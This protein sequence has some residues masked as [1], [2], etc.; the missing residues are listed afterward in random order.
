MFDLPKQY[1]L[2]FCLVSIGLQL[3]LNWKLNCNY[4]L[5]WTVMT[6]H[7]IGWVA[8][9]SVVRIHL[10]QWEMKIEIG[11]CGIVDVCQ[12]HCLYRPIYHLNILWFRF[13]PMKRPFST[14]ILCE[15]TINLNFRK[16]RGL[17]SKKSLTLA[18][19]RTKTSCSTFLESSSSNWTFSRPTL[20]CST[21][22]WLK[23]FTV[24]FSSTRDI[25]VP[26]FGRKV[27]KRKK[28]FKIGYYKFT[29]KQK[30]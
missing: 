17:G 27:P 21:I 24:N 1:F 9:R 11:N 20:W 15:V 30:M 2:S 28:L 14:Q 8:L 16:Q 7:A 25:V 29:K 3:I 23:H 12:M 26:E 22:A 13:W 10:H 6:C 4:L 5:I 19:A 18:F